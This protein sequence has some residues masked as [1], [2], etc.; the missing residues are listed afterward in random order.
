[1]SF[2]P[3]KTINLSTALLG[4]AQPF[5]FTLPEEKIETSN[6]PLSGSSSGKERVETRKPLVTNEENLEYLSEKHIHGPSKEETT[7]ATNIYTIILVIIS[8][9]IFVTV[10]SIYDII[11]ALI[12]NYY[13]KKTLEDPV[14]NN[15]TEDIERTLLA[16]NN[17][18]YASF[19]FAGICVLTAVI[20]IP[21]LLYLYKRLV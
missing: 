21:L 6:L 18:F 8:A 11:R 2:M 3:V 7:N 19:V 1:M 13:A 20:F 14:S 5:R 4:A 10:V 16:N 12:T 17:A 9:I 15:T